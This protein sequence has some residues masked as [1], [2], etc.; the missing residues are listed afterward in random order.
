M[1]AH[2]SNKASV[3]DFQGVLEFIKIL[4][5]SLDIDGR[6]VQLGLIFYGLD[7]EVIFYI[8]Q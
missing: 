5:N 1:A 7:P 4:A 3:A 6:R 8:D 2:V